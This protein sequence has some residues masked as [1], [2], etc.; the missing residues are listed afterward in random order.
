MVLVDTSIWSLALRRRPDVLDSEQ[1]ALLE[2]WRHLVRRGSAVLIGPIRQE[3]LSGIRS[4]AQFESIREALGSFGYLE[5]VALDYDEAARLFNTCR[6]NGITA[7]AIDLLICTVARRYDVPIFTTDPD[8]DHLAPHAALR[9]H[10]D[11][12]GF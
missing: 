1:R 3:V 8:F 7:T 12:L 5:I 9:L 4:E 10:R 2:E 11:S 6:S